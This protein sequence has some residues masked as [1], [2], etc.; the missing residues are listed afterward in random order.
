MIMP[1]SHFYETKELASQ[2]DHDDIATWFL[3]HGYYPEQYVLPPCF[4]SR[5]FELNPQLYF[6][7]EINQGRSKLRAEISELLEISLPR[8]MLTQRDYSI[9]DP[10]HYHDMVFHIVNEWDTLLDHLFPEDQNIFSYSFP[11]PLTRNN[12]GSIGLMRAGRMIYEFLAMA[13]SDLIAEAY[14]YK[15]LVRTDIKNFSKNIYYKFI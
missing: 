2:L 14:K 1:K 7:I 6:P 12:P 4:N 3:K 5:G 13:E 9:I 15:Y 8:T 11:I 10:R